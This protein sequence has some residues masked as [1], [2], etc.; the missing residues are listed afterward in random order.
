MIGPAFHLE[1]KLK[2]TFDVLGKIV[3]PNHHRSGPWTDADG[4]GCDV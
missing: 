3:P 2:N 4:W 1:L